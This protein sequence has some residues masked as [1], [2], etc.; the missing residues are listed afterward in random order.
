MVR[1]TVAAIL[2]GTASLA[3]LEPTLDLRAIEQAIAIGLARLDRER[4][5]FHQPY[6]LN[7]DRPPI[8]YLEIISPFRRV[9]LAAEQR[10]R[11]G[12]RSFSQRQ[13]LELLAVTPGLIEVRAE[14][15]FH[16]MHALASVPDYGI[17]LVTTGGQ[18]VTA[19]SLERVPRFGPRVDGLPV[20]MPGVPGALPL[21]GTQPMLGGTVI[22][23]FD[24]LRLDANGVYDV[25][26]VEKGRELARTR[27]VLKSLR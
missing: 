12:E 20:P 17:H 26:V 3:A 15:T 16:P 21:P 6:R 13:A 24:G 25:L 22:A 10:L 1:G 7:V 27:L 9:A 23:A 4:T 18:V 8:D 14:L 5:A 2:I 19:G 11:L